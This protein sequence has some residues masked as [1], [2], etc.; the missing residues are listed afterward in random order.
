M[1]LGNTHSLILVFACAVATPLL[2]MGVF[3]FIPSTWTESTLNLGIVFFTLYLVVVGAFTLVC[4]RIAQT[5]ELHQVLIFSITALIVVRGKQLLV[6]TTE[7]H[8]IIEAGTLFGACL[9]VF[10]L[11]LLMQR[12][13]KK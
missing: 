10:C 2:V 8:E 6:S 7:L 4:F 13:K 1:K 5:F 11:T 9:L 12:R 3:S